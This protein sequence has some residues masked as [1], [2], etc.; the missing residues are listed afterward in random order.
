MAYHR[1]KF[2]S[3][4]RQ[5]VKGVERKRG[6]KIGKRFLKIKKRIGSKDN[7]EDG[8]ACKN[9]ETHMLG[10]KKNIGFLSMYTC[11]IKI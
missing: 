8:K 10:Y 7:C 9:N 11:I 2:I 3:R 1:F 4:H 6:N 5:Q